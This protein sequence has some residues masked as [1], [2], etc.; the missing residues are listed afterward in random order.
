MTDAPQYFATPDPLD[1]GKVSYW[2]RAQTGLIQPWPPRRSRWGQLLKADVPFDK[3][4]TPGEY[5]E[6]VNAH[7][8]KVAAARGQAKTVIEQDPAA[9]SA[10]FAAFTTR[11]CYCGKALSDQR[12]KVY[13]IGPDCRGDVAPAVLA[14]AM[15][16]VRAAH[17]EAL[18]R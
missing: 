12:S 3:V 17:G 15:E 13:G 14:A 8:A 4:L 18:A 2:Y 9:A 10:R 11:C 7:F 6:F 1:A 16:A 5:R